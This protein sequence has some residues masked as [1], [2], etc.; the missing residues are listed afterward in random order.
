MTST[1]SKAVRQIVRR[2]HVDA[3]TGSIWNADGVRVG[4][5]TYEPRISIR[6]TTAQ[7][8]KKYN[9]RISKVIGFLKYGSAAVRKYS[10]IRHADGDKSN[11]RQENLIL[12]TRPRTRRTASA[13]R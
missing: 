1:N 3:A 8:R 2:Y 10:Q 7:G 5:N 13:T 12:T 4:S 11:N 9:V 6:L